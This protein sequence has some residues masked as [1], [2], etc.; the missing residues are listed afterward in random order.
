MVLDGVPLLQGFHAQSK[1]ASDINGIALVLWAVQIEHHLV[2]GPRPIE[3]GDEPVMKNVEE[4][5]ERIVTGIALAVAGKFR[6]VLGQGA[7]GPEEPEVMHKK[8]RNGTGSFAAK[9]F[10]GGRS[11]GER[12][13]LREPDRVMGGRVGIADA[14]AFRMLTLQQADGPEQVEG[15][16]PL[17]QFLDYIMGRLPIIGGH[18]MISPRCCVLI[19]VS[20]KELSETYFAKN[21]SSTAPRMKTPVPSNAVSSN[22]TVI[23]RP[24]AKVIG[25]G[26]STRRTMGW[27][28]TVRSPSICLM[29]WRSFPSVYNFRISR[30]AVAP[31]S[32]DE[33]SSER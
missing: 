11:E 5:H 12:G 26:A 25:P 17:L 28:R 24:R 20:V 30:S 7:V 18:R 3:Q 32:P 15:E 22:V 13:V 4:G 14:G 19:T 10:D 33:S 27:Q 16:G 31:S 21:C 23:S 29:V 6:E 9:G 1:E 2:V 8:P